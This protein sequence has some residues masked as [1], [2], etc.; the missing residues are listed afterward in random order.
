MYTYSPGISSPRNRYPPI[1]RIAHAHAPDVQLMHNSIHTEYGHT[2]TRRSLYPVD[3]QGCPLRRLRSYRSFC[4]PVFLTHSAL[5]FSAKSQLC[6]PKIWWTSHPHLAERASDNIHSG[7]PWNT[8]CLAACHYWAQLI[9]QI[10]CDGAT[11][12][13]RNA[14]Y[15][16]SVRVSQF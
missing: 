7:I 3:V 15:N 6:A 14:A 16:S 5:S 12:N 4:N 1:L 10:M 8:L 9:G 11:T 2:S 13:L